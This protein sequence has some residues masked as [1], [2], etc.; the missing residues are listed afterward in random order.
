MVDGVNRLL[1]LL[2]GL[3]LAALGGLGLAAGAGWF[4]EL[5]SP[6]TI[7]DDARA[8]VLDDPDLWYAVVLGASGGVLVL[9]LVWLLRQLASRPGGPH[10][11][12]VVL[13]AGRRGR[14]TLEPVKLA[15]AIAR[16]L[17]TVD[18]V[19]RAKVRIRSTGHEPAVRVR[20]TTDRAVDPDELLANIEPVFQ[21]AAQSLEATDV[22]ARTRID[23]A[24]RDESRVA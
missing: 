14:T 15:R 1:L 7:Y 19:R 18:G 6:A 2:L 24:G 10:L 13:E 3:A 11:S 12:T 9:A 23:F 21:R 4:E 5:D 8:Q 22:E 20:L 17:E 16:D